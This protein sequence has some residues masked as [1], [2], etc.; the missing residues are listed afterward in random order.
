M[1]N[2]SYACSYNNT[3]MISC[4]YNKDS[5]ELSLSFPSF[6]NFPIFPDI[7]III[8][9]V[10]FFIL[11]SLVTGCFGMMI[12]IIYKEDRDVVPQVPINIPTLHINQG[13]V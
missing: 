5:S 12:G 8:V 4:F 6:E 9:V 13:P 2:I 7:K 3:A 1:Y 11:G 10:L